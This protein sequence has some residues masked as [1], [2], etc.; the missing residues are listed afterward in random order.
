M[1]KEFYVGVKGLILVGGKCL[2]LKRQKTDIAYW[3]VPGGRVE[4]SE[5]LEEALARELREELP[6]LKNFT[7][8]NVVS[9]HRLGMDLSDGKGLVF[10]FFRIEAEHFD[11]V[12]TNEHLGYVWIGKDTIE[13]L[14]GSEFVI[15][16]KYYDAISRALELG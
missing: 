9:A 13:E 8:G 11:I 7:I 6:S 15:E 16:E 2:V 3:D 4:G 14:K 12:L 5:S 1:E 10:V